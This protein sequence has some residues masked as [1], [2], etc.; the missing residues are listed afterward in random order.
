M[1][2][3]GRLTSGGWIKRRRQVGQAVADTQRASLARKADS[4]QGCLDW[5]KSGWVPYLS[6]T[7]P[8]C[9]YYHYYYYNKCYYHYYCHYY[10]CYYVERPVVVTLTPLCAAVVNVF[11]AKAITLVATKA[12][13]AASASI[14][15]SPEQ[16]FVIFACLHHGEGIL[17]VGTL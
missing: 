2:V 15:L 10:Y 5:G 1:P 14:S 3:A 16:Y 17:R 12:G 9:H 8:A 4:I 6:R 7:P 11:A 13:E